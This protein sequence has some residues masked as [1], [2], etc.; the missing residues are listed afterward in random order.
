[1]TM[2]AKYSYRMS[3]VSVEVSMKDMP[4][5]QDIGSAENDEDLFGDSHSN[6]SLFGDGED[7]GSLFGD[8]DDEDISNDVLR[9]VEV[10]EPK[11]PTPRLS[12]PIP[13][14][15]PV[16][17]G[18][19][20]PPTGSDP[21]GALS[22]IRVGHTSDPQVVSN[23]NPSGNEQSVLPHPIT[24]VQQLKKMEE[25]AG[26][27]GYEQTIDTF[28]PNSHIHGDQAGHGSVE[29]VFPSSLDPVSDTDM[30]DLVVSDLERQL[31]YDLLQEC[32][33]SDQENTPMPSDAETRQ[34]PPPLDTP[35]LDKVGHL[36]DSSVDKAPLKLPRQ[37]D[38]DESGINFLTR[39]VSLSK[40]IRF[41]SLIL[42]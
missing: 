23:P 38:L 6:G 11:A 21:R 19:T 14:A 28:A 29:G 17:R 1:M 42:C 26:Q 15:Q 10:H 36:S 5:L 25:V 16:S 4:S 39:Y 2:I 40:F 37:V 41:Y 20:L 33:M 3:P 12:L 27:A 8:A 13:A 9:S 31:E 22:S 35:G 30:S 24:G 18:L 32:V 7:A 34:Q